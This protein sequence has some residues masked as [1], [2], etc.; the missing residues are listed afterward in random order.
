MNYTDHP[1]NTR[2]LFAPSGW[3]QAALQCDALPVTD[4]LVGNN[5][6]AIQSFWRP[7]PEELQALNEGGVV[8]LSIIG[9]TMPPVMLQVTEPDPAHGRL[10]FHYDR[11]RDVMTIEG[12]KY[13]GAMFRHFGFGA[14]HKPFWMLKREDGTITISTLG[15]TARPDEISDEIPRI[16]CI[17]HDCPVCQASEALRTCLAARVEQLEALVNTPQTADFL[18]AV[19]LEA[20]HQVQRWGYAHDRSKSAENWFWLV[21]YL[22]G[23]ALRA[24]I[25]GDKMKA[26]HH[27]ISS[28]AA[29]LNWH[30]AI[31]HDTTGAGIGQDADLRATN[32][33]DAAAADHHAGVTD[34]AAA[35]PR[36]M[37]CT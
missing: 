3:D 8:L 17:G 5:T 36:W 1:T 21:G 27:T 9:S 35:G 22:C 33:L 18:E 14:L 12:I 25:T 29:L 23:K 31:T 34:G 26:L 7:E 15:T 28:A 16:G 20:A 13:S 30:A 4:A 24:A 19:R 11:H 2:K 10:Q 6:P 32:P 37:K